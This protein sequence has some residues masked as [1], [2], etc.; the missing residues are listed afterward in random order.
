L[1]KQPK[2]TAS[3]FGVGIQIVRFL[4]G[5]LRRQLLP[6]LI[7]QVATAAVEMLSLGV[8]A[9][10]ASI[11]SDPGYVAEKILA[12]QTWGPRLPGVL[13]TVVENASHLIV[14]SS[15]LVVVA[16]GLKNCLQL[17]V[18]YWSGRLAANVDGFIGDQLMSRYMAM[19]YE[20]H[21]DKNPADLIQTVQW[22]G[23][24]GNYF[25]G[26]TLLT[27]SDVFLIFMMM[28][29]VLVA[30]PLILIFAII[31]L[32]IGAFLIFGRIKKVID[33]LTVKTRDLY[34]IINRLI[35]QLLYGVKDVKISAREN[36]FLGTFETGV[37]T[38]ARYQA[39]QRIINRAPVWLL[40]TAGFAGIAL[41]VIILIVVL[42]VPIAKL[43][44]IL[45]LIAVSAW[46]I[47]PAINRIL[48]G[49][50]TLREAMPYIQ[51]IFSYID[52]LGSTKPPQGRMP[53]DKTPRPH[54][55]KEIRLR[56]VAFAYA[57][58]DEIILQDIDIAIAKGNTVG[59]VGL[60]G[61]GKSTLADIL[62][63]LL[64]PTGGGVY[65]DGTRLSQR[66][67]G[68]WRQAVGYVPQHPYIVDG[69]I[70][71]NVAFG[72]APA[73]ISREKVLACCRMAAMDFL[74][75]MPEGIDTVVGER[76]AK[77]SG[78]QQQRIAIARAL[79]KEPQVIIFD[80]A[81]SSLDSKSERGILQTIYSLKGKQTL[82][83]IAHRLNTVEN[84]DVVIW[85]N[86]GQTEKIGRPSEVLAAYQEEEIEATS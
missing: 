37:Y 2:Q 3:I 50:A 66:S 45:A 77:I 1:I 57:A 79:Y 70:V 52:L 51:K 30:D 4:P 46:R 76:G 78:G 55:R 40:E 41:T 73:E 31:V 10:W 19:P 48:T 14:A 84:C 11:V 15:V 8:I 83:I 58:R 13:T 39:L 61:S 67:R 86:Q 34:L 18:T 71:E 68:A 80:E 81:T 63:G 64:A 5:K 74:E 62:I 26:T 65:I 7:I 20:W 22:R 82:I 43:A 75:R 54:F 44:G 59:I 29:A 42:A 9:A 60:S 85:L 36:Q 27:L 56:D 47:L 35:N 49:M 21:T 16:I 53:S 25:I 12:S 32:G 23:Y 38:L 24:F 28:A 33:R 6:L 72:Y 69:S 17:M